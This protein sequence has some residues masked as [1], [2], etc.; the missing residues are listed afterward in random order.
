MKKI[1]LSM[2]LLVATTIGAAPLE[3]LSGGQSGRIEFRSTTPQGH[4]DMIRNDKLTTRD[5]I[6]WGDLYMPK[7]IN[8]KVAAVVMSHGVEGVANTHDTYTALWVRSLNNAGIAA[9]LVDSYSPR[10]MGNLSGAK[11]LNLNATINISDAIHALKILS[12]HPQID[13]TKIF[14]IGWSL[15][16]TV[17]L[18]AS[19]PAYGKYILPPGVHWAGSVGM[20]GGCNIKTRVDHLGTNTAPVL[21]LLG[22]T[23]DNTPASYCVDYARTLARDGNKVSY[24]VY[25]GAGHDFDRYE[26]RP[27]QFY[28]GLYRDCDI[29]V[30]LSPQPGAPGAGYDFVQNKRLNGWDEIKAATDSCKKMGNVTI[31]GQRQAREQ[32]VKD[33]LEFI[34][35]NSKQMKGP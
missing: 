11:S 6:V 27:R 5:E 33:V 3:D 4:Q 1:L 20:Y 28:H 8:G 14:N 13:S 19:F 25:P 34:N 30:K 31:A 18:D 2:A 15:G 7:N 32:S 17:A 16:G 9:F 26:E 24:K 29:E 35:A 22:E 23:D 10:S 12:T 21:L